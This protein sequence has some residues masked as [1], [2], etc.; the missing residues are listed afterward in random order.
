MNADSDIQRDVFDELVW[1]PSIEHDHIS[2]SVKDGIVALSGT[3]SSY[4]E[5]SAAENAVKR[6]YGVRGVMENLKVD[7]FASHRRDDASIAEAAANAI[8]WNASVPRGKVKAAVEGAWI[9]LSGDVDWNFQREAAHNAVRYLIGVKG[10]TDAIKVHAAPK[11]EAEVR[12]RIEAAVRR[13]SVK[14]AEG[15]V[16]KVEAGKV[17]LSGN[18]YT[19]VEHDAVGRAAWATP[20]VSAVENELLVTY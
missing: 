1:E 5:R 19:W 4:G 10:V 11:S 9:T 6:V 17:T 8:E 20:G 14:N 2:V 13:Y 7:L 3:V 18:V 15:I 16:V 12:M